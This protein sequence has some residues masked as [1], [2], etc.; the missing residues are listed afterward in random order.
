MN[1]ACLTA[2]GAM[3]F[4]LAFCAAARAQELQTVL[5]LLAQGFEIRAAY[6]GSIVMQRGRDVYLCGTQANGGMTPDGYISSHCVPFKDR[7]Q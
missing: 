5:T 2:T 1:R 3:A 6:P 4:A 7:R